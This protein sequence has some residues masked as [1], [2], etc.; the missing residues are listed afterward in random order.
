MNMVYLKEILQNLTNLKCLTLIFNFSFK[1][2]VKIFIQF[3]N[4]K[5]VIR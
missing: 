2:R 3:K 5:I 4:F 1:R